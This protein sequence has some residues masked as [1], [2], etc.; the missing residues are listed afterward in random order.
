MQIA[1]LVVR[2]RLLRKA[3][4]G[5]LPV[6]HLDVE[7]ALVEARHRHGNPVGILIGPQNVVGRV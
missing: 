3:L 2:V 5:Q 7:L 4:D 6:M 1:D